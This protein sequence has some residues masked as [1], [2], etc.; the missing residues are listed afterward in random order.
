[1]ECVIALFFLTPKRWILT[2]RRIFQCR[3]AT[4]G[5]AVPKARKILC[6]AAG[7]GPDIHEKP[8]R[9]EQTA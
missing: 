4:W 6:A 2:A 5:F 7:A 9:E 8:L 3:T 1:M